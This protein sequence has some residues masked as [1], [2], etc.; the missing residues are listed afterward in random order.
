MIRA[1]DRTTTIMFI[2]AKSPGQSTHVVHA[3]F[4]FGG[5]GGGGRMLPRLNGLIVVPGWRWRRFNG[6][7]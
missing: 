2:A 7:G 3:N 1:T 5:G 4:G 6:F